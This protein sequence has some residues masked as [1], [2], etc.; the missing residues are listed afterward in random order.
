MSHI[1]RNIEDIEDFV[2]GTTYFG[3]G[4][5]GRPEEGRQYLTS[6][7]DEGFEIEFTDP[8]QIPDDLWCCSAFGMGSIA[9]GFDQ[10]IAPYGLSKKIV[11]QPAVEAIRKLEEHASVKIGVVIPFELGGANTARGMAAGIRVGAVIP[12]GDFCGRAVP[13]LSQTTVAISGVDATPISICDDWG[14]VIIVKSVATI[15]VAE[16]IGKLIS[17]ITKAPDAKAQCAH[18]AF[19]MKAKDM[20]KFLVSGTLSKSLKVGKAIRQARLSGD[21]PIKALLEAS[22]SM[23]LFKG[24][25]ESNDWVNKDGYM[26]GTHTINGK[27]EY[28]GQRLGVWYK[29][30]NHQ[31]KIDDKV[32]AMS[33]DMIH[34]VLEDTGEPITN[35]KIVQGLDVVVT[36]TPNLLYRT[37]E[38]L[39]ALG[40][41]HFG[42]DTQYIPVEKYLSKK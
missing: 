4:G 22:G 6:C 21:D 9:P 1:L 27:G 25:V 2:R 17:T 32:V 19:L 42:F 8:S 28:Q 13:E 31:A 41:K 10:K 5:G 7:I 18:A 37:P 14:N 15:D 34:L 35:A 29:N 33:P 36:V 3:T 20:K 23:L 30:E 26:I 11:L 12:D 40:P 38:A 24:K 39:E 16:A